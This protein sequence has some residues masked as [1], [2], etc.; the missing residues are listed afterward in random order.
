MTRIAQ[1]IGLTMGL[2]SAIASTAP[3]ALADDARA[4]YDQ[5]L[6]LYDGR[7]D[8]AKNDRAIELLKQAESTVVDR[9]LKFDILVLA[10]RAIYWQG[11]TTAGPDEDNN[12]K[13]AVFE[14]GIAKAKFAVDLEPDF[15]DGY[16]YYA[17]NLARWGQAKG[18]LNA[19]FRL[20]ELKDYLK[21][22]LARDTKDGRTGEE[23]E[24]YGANRILGRVYWKVP[25]VAGGD[26]K[27]SAALL[28]KAFEKAPEL[29]LNV[30]Y[31]AETLASLGDKDSA[32]EMLKNMLAQ[33]PEDYG[34]K[35]N[36]VPETIL[37]FQ[38]GRKLLASLSR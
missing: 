24:A 5:A 33:K 20:E 12:A 34:K 2:L 9:Q 30:V 11:V 15:A 4:L 8:L 37:E 35:L 6:A 38:E 10:S 19:L 17:L 13:V 1:A 32:R 29:A 3:L 26:K 21:A 28:K 16:F 23:F 27:K 36:R 31:Y 14:R 22:T 25:T 7:A 18:T